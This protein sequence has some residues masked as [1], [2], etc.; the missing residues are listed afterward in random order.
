MSESQIILEILNKNNIN[1][2]GNIVK[3]SEDKEQ[4]YVQVEVIRDRSN[5]QQPSNLKLNSVK[6]S[7]LEGGLDVIFLIFHKDSQDIEAGLRAALLHLFGNDIRNVFVTL[8]STNV[9]VLIDP[10]RAFD[11]NT[12]TKIRERVIKYLEI[13]ELKLSNFSN[14]LGDNLPNKV[15][16]LNAIK[17]ISPASL[18]EIHKQ[19]IKKEFTVPSSDW[20]ARKLDLF[21]KSGNVVRLSNKNYVLSAS[22]LK[23]LG[24]TTGRRS[25]D[26]TRL[27]ALAR[28]G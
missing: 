23:A 27:L 15:A 3:A 12:T 9:N 20:V 1:V 24:S 18:E 26:L 14:T 7:L 19:L 5:K 2:V 21:R 17:I 25:S 6:K 28:A 10:K 13:S 4:Y 8:D 16:F 22:S 11:E